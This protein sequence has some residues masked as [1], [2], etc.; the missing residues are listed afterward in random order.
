MAF[1]VMSAAI[2]AMEEGTAVTE[3]EGEDF[4]G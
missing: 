4:V 1:S 2:A 3:G